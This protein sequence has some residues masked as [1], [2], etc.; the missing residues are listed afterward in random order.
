MKFSKRIG[1]GNIPLNFYQKK[2]ITNNKKAFHLTFSF[3]NK[4]NF[5][6]DNFKKNNE[7]I[8]KNDKK[9]FYKNTINKSF[10]KT[11]TK[12]EVSFIIKE[13]K[14]KIDSSVNIFEEIF[15]RGFSSKEKLVKY[16]DFDSISNNV[17]LEGKITLESINNSIFIPC[18]DIV[19][20][21]GKRWRPILGLM[22]C[23]LF[24]IDLT[25][26]NNNEDKKLFYKLLYLVESLHNAS[27][28]IDDV[29]DKSE[30]RR[31]LPCIHLKYGEA[32]AINAGISFLFFP[33]YKI[34]HDIK[35]PLMIADLSKT[36]L[37]EISS[38]HVGQGWDIEMNVNKRT[39]SKEDYNDTVLMKTG[40]FP[41]FIVKLLKILVKDQLIKSGIK[42]KNNEENYIENIFNKLVEIVD[43]M[44]IAFQI[45][46]DLLN[47]SESDLAKGK[48]FF[49]EDIF[50]G[51]LTLMVLHTLNKSIENIQDKEKVENRQR[52][53]EEIFNMKTK[54]PLLIKEAVQIL[55]INGS[56]EFAENKM[57][58]HVDKAILICDELIND[59]CIKKKNKEF[60]VEAIDYIKHM[61]FYL[62]DRSI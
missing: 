56:I 58:Y 44:S 23:D 17:N 2:K 29:E 41:R 9:I 20:R 49:G 10:S 45:K 31:N 24:K 11:I 43:N 37:Q 48:G 32:I 6:F 34:I 3:I 50:E 62:I 30:S 19:D 7:N 13:Y 46:D 52:R 60:N 8:F 26:P 27:L 40:V 59:I 4:N 39:P 28:I 1:L 18:W 35:N 15:P 61:I 54:E 47:I 21:G 55:K 5:F 33:F 51:K 25:D 36:F 53:F 22:I 16:F 12:K 42:N 14:S 57:N 38:L